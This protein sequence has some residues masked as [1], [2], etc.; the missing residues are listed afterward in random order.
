MWQNRRTSRSAKGRTWEGFA[1]RRV[2]CCESETSSQSA[3][4]ESP[5]SYCATT[6]ALD[7]KSNTSNTRILVRLAPAFLQRSNFH[8]MSCANNFAAHQSRGKKWMIIFKL[9]ECLRVQLC[10]ALKETRQVRAHCRQTNW[11]KRKVGEVDDKESKDG[12]QSFSTS[13]EQQTSTRSI[14][15]MAISVS[16]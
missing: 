3:D 8:S 2:V 15:L 10:N 11:W 7:S 5:D 14:R 16:H 4:R 6:S 12:V 1:D 9:N 13:T